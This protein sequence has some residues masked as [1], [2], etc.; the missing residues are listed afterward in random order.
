MKSRLIFQ[1]LLF[2]TLLLLPC[3]IYKVKRCFEKGHTFRLR[4]NDLDRYRDHSFGIFT[5]RGYPLFALDFDIEEKD[6]IETL[7]D[8]ISISLVVGEIGWAQ[9]S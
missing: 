3:P 6:L 7:K 1:W 8:E 4:E 9:R 2:S 5:G